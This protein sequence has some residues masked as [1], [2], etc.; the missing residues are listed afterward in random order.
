MRMHV[1]MCCQERERLLRVMSR[2][3]WQDLAEPFV[4][5]A[6]TL[7]V[8]IVIGATYYDSCVGL[9]KAF[10]DL[11]YYPRSLALAACIGNP[12]LYDDVGKDL[13]WISGP[14]QVCT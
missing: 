7:D 6:K 9:I 11:E 14:T 3:C 8:D 1:Q 10:G 13:R 5:L 2:T 4:E 12:K